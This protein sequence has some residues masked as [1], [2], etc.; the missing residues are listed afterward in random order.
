MAGTKEPA[1]LLCHLH[2]SDQ[3]QILKVN[4]MSNGY[5]TLDYM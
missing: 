2:V 4:I 3:V 5:V 1:D